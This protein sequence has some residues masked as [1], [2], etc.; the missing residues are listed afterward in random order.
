[1]IAAWRTNFNHNR[2]HTSLAGL[3]PAGYVNRSEEGQN[4][5]RANL[6]K[7]AHRGAGQI[8]PTR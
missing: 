6:N 4:M 7:R 2:P 8:A 1:M 5:N 3:T